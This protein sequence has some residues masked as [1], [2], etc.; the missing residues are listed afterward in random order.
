MQLYKQFLEHDVINHIW[1]F[2][3]DFWFK[4]I[5][6]TH[7]WI[8]IIIIVFFIG[9]IGANHWLLCNDNGSSIIGQRREVSLYSQQR[10]C[11]VGCLSSW[12]QYET[13]CRYIYLNYFC[14]C[15]TKSLSLT[16]MVA[17]KQFMAVSLTFSL[18]TQ[19]WPRVR[20][21]PPMLW[22]G[23]IIVYIGLQSACL[24]VTSTYMYTSTWFFLNFPSQGCW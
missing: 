7:F 18:P 9:K 19:I 24:S 5:Y 20:N 21:R 6:W 4:K 13:A 8:S 1:R 15:C 17:F 14:R 22:S 16:I 10:R 11:Y 23:L 2:W 12:W 3:L